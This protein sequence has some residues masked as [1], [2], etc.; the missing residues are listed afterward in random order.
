MSISLLPRYQKSF[1]GKL[2]NLEYKPHH[3]ILQMKNPDKTTTVVQI[4][5]LY[6][7]PIQNGGPSK[8]K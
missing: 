7:N 4:R 6:V 1:P 5:G 2:K 3:V 8:L